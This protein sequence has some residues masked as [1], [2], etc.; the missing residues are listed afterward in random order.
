LD[1]VIKKKG[2]NL[3]QRSQ[4][5]GK[6]AVLGERASYG[7][8]NN[9]I[10][11]IEKK[12][13][14]RGG[15]TGKTTKEVRPL[16]GKRR[17]IGKEKVGGGDNGRPLAKSSQNGGGEPVN[18]GGG[19]RYNTPT[20]R[21]KKGTTTGSQR[22]DC[23][24]LICLGKKKRSSQPSKQT[25]VTKRGGVSLRNEGASNHDGRTKGVWGKTKKRGKQ[26]WI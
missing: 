25:R 21:G 24:Q 22:K 23:R 18:E 13:T 20:T 17:K 6:G 8:S 9:K 1:N 2:K 7:T 12:R 16:S 3:G 14:K 19:G 5:K 10:G 4:Q 15:G 26:V 11:R